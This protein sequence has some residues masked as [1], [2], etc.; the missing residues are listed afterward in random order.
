MAGDDV[1]EA[2]RKRLM[3]ALFSQCHQF[4]TVFES[5]LKTAGQERE[6]RALK[7]VASCSAAY[8]RRVSTG[9]NGV[10]WKNL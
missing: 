10:S 2:P 9:H 6:N 1:Y 4:A 7:Q 5:V 8:F 3:V